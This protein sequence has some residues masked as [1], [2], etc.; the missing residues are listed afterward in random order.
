[1]WGAVASALP[2]L[3]Q[4]PP[5]ALDRALALL[6]QLGAVGPDDRPTARGRAMA[7]LPVH[8]RLAAMLVEGTR[9]GQVTRAAAL[10][11]LLEDRDVLRGRPDEVPADLA[12]RLA[13]LLDRRGEHP[14]ADRDA[15]RT[16]RRRADE[17]RRRAERLTIA[18]PGTASPAPAGNADEPGPLLA[19]AY[20]DRV[21]QARGGGRFRLRD[22]PGAFLPATDGL[23]RE[24]F[25][26]VADL[27]ATRDARNGPDGR[28]R[29]AAAL[30]ATDVERDLG[31]LAATTST[32]AWDRE[33]DDLRVT[34][35]RR[36][37]ALVL[38]T[39]VRKPSPGPLTTAAL[40][41][42]VRATGLGALRWSASARALQARAAFAAAATPAWPDLRDAALL[43]ALDEWLAPLLAGATGRADLEAVDLTTA[44]RNRLGHHRVAQLDQLAPTR[45]PV[46]S[47][48]TVAVD[49]TG[50]QP[51]IEVR[52]QELYGTTT[53]PTIAGGRVPL[54]VTVLSPAGRPVQVTADL[55]GFW[56]GSWRDVRKD[57]AGR[58]PRH[59]WPV[60]PATAAPSTRPRRRS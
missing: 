17:L 28:I 7:V 12:D 8:P 60:D 43:D 56:A 10:A 32:L 36:L 5:A 3:D 54:L 58:Y 33:R 37:D 20:P 11:A 59:D 52:A 41:D 22:G 57:M 55:P 34:E 48:R 13:L 9:R 26:V 40:V 23:A 46:A 53:H 4:P 19:V 35:T 29:L 38:D 49:Y 21:A 47:G 42:H 39:R 45:V 30:D 2:F 18:S 24:G 15:L 16:A 44:L 27:D 51:A 25:L 50:A 14:H 1:M 31:A 6:R